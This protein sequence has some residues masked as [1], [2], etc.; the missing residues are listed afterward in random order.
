MHVCVV[1]GDPAVHYLNVLENWG[2]SPRLGCG[3]QARLQTDPLSPWASHR[4]APP[5]QCGL[6]RLWPRDSSHCQ[7]QKVECRK[8]S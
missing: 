1:V 5:D 2:P 4:K 8:E 6:H 3:V 7:K